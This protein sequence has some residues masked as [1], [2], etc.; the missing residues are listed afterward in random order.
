MNKRGGKRA[1]NNNGIVVDDLPPAGVN[2][3][4]EE[5][6]KGVIMDQDIMTKELIKEQKKIK[7]SKFNMKI[8]S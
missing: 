4:I 6:Q 1:D 3:L 5:L 7:R 2:E 8:E